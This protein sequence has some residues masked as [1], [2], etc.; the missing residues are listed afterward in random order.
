MKKC[1][2]ILL[3]AGLAL[4]LAIG[5][6]NHEEEKP[7]TPGNEQQK[8]SDSPKGEDKD[9][10]KD[11][12]SDSDGQSDAASDENQKTCKAGQFGAE[13]KP[14]TCQNGTCKDGKDGNGECSSC[15]AGYAGKNCDSMADSKGRLYKVTKIDNQVWMAENMATDQA[16]DGTEVTCYA[17]TDPEDG[18]TDFVEKYGCLYTWADAQRICPS[19]WHLPT[20]SDFDTL[21]NYVPEHRKSNN[22]FLALIAKSTA[23]TG[24]SNQGGDDF[25]FGALPAGYGGGGYGNFG[26]YA[27]FWSATEN[28]NYTD[29]AYSLYLGN[30]DADVDNIYKD[31]A[32]SVRCLKDSP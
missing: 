26:T 22:N 13:C 25:A 14:C 7:A 12:S 29:I 28:E 8:P 11:A 5:C 20:Y 23:W 27:Y 21:L 15:E 18:D 31:I 17:N 9:K 24:Y 32:F 2:N 3:F 30:G 19:G 4:F 16:T 6:G 10:D 1:K